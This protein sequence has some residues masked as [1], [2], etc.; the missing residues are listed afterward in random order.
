MPNIG[1][2][3]ELLTEFLNPRPEVAPRPASIVKLGIATAS[4]AMV[5]ALN[6]PP[7]VGFF[8]T[9]N[10]I[11]VFYICLALLFV[12]GLGLIIFSWLATNHARDYMITVIRASQI[13]L[14][15]AIALYD[16]YTNE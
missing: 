9:E 7:S 2:I 5:A 10:G 14:V 3:N 4:I 13:M 15:F 8:G 6:D 1:F 11:Y 16:V 12:F